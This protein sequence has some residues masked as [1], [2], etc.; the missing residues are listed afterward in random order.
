LTDRGLG[1]LLIVR[2]PGGFVGGRVSDALVSHVDLYPTLCE[3]AVAP[4][5]DGLAGRS[6]LPLSR[7][8]TTDVRDELFAE[9]TYHVAYDPQRAIRTKRYKLIRRFGDRLE[10][11][12]A[13]VDD[14]PSK[15]VLVAA[16]W[17]RRPRPRVELHDLL[18]DPGE[19]RNLAGDP[20]LGAVREDL[21][22]RLH[23]WMV[24]TDDPLL[25]GPVPPPPGALVNDPAALSPDAPHL[26]EI[27]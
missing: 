14:S 21:E 20:E 22:R 25:H 6:L 15:E 10:P 2:G 12:L 19:L 23:D 8:E 9:L 27:D 26:A 18:L 4:L 13:N 3:L 16:G 24:A 17:G 1:V 11:V 7:G 5:P